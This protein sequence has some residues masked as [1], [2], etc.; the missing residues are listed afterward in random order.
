MHAIATLTMNPALDVSTSTPKVEPTHKLRCGTPRYDPGGGGI[1]VARVVKMLG[2]ESIAVYPAGGP[3]GEVLRHSLD[4]L[5]LTQCVVPI[6]G[7][8]R[9]N[10]TV[11]EAE[12][13]EQYR[14]VLPGPSLSADETR[15]CFDA[16]AGLT[17]RPSY[18]VVSGGYPPGADAHALSVEIERLAAWIGA[19]LILD[20][21]R[22][23]RYAPE[24]GAFLMKPSLSELCVMAG[25]E[26]ATRDEQI[27][28]ARG[29][30]Q[31]GHAEALVVSLA[32]EGALLVTDT[33]AE[34][35]SAPEVPIRSAV[36]AGDS[37]V[38]AIV[39]ALEKGWSL[40]E[41]VRYGV[42]AGAATIMTPGTELCY[43]EDVE[44][45]Y[46]GMT[47]GRMAAAPGAA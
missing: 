10:F 27:V 39:L 46:G 17:P 25:R 41:A 47:G 44:R 4:A 22:A 28:A 8:T 15:A 35:F 32:E 43:R 29:F 18:L 5:G 3:A 40:T 24:H 42:A 37:M 1:N 38:G 2:G 34:H 33:L 26:L 36:G 21:S 13:G 11:N 16:I 7:A 12:S 19:R 31:D 14:F 30:V 20:T 6:A 23:M 45:L 9:E